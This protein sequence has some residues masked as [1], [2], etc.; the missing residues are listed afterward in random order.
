[1]KRIAVIN[2]PNLNLLGT[3]EPDVYGHETLKDLEAGLAGLAEELGVAVSFFQSNHEGEIIDHIHGLR[4]EAAA[5]LINPGG[6]THTSVSLRDA[7]SGVE[8]PVYEVHISNVH[9]REEFRHRSLVSGVAVGVVC[10]LGL[11]GYEYAL[12][13]AAKHVG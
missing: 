9:S 1:M 12:R 10:G 5:L 6:L 2:G 7:L 8:L 13:E 3:R 11:R 4:G